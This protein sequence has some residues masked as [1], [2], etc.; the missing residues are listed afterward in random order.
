M[1]LGNH[2]PS[3][4]PTQN[5]PEFWDP[6]SLHDDG[7]LRIPAPYGAHVLPALYEVGLFGRNV[8]GTIIFS[9]V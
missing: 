2:A 6:R 5:L 9:S 1:P 7:H 3:P 4:V 8:T